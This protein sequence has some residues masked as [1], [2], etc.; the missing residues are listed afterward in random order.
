MP[1]PQ[2][3]GVSQ[4]IDGSASELLRSAR[5]WHPARTNLGASL[6]WSHVEAELDDVAIGHDVV[7]ALHADLAGGLGGGHRTGRHQVVVRDDLGLDEATLEVGVDDACG[8]GCGGTALD[9]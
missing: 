4:V 8:F 7:L 9:G 2:G 1:A 3:W 6:R 5:S